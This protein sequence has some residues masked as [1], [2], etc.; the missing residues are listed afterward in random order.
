MDRCAS[1]LSGGRDSAHLAYAY[2][3]T[4]ARSDAET[5]VRSLLDPAA[6]REVLPFHLAMAYAGLGDVDAAFQWLE[7]GHEE[8]ASFMD[9]IMVTPAFDV[10]RPDPRWE[11]LLRR[12][13]LAP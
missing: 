8:R 9:G 6:H 4:G 10:L 12:M 3:V 11:R 2:A 5:I 1:E 13:R 7:R